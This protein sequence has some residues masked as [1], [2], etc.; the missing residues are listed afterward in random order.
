M[1]RAS[2]RCWR[3]G[4][5][6]AA[7]VLRRWDDLASVSHAIGNAR[8]PGTPVEGVIEPAKPL[9]LAEVWGPRKPGKAPQ[10]SSA[11][12]KE[13]LAPREAPNPTKQQ[14]TKAPPPYKE[15][16]APPTGPPPAA[17]AATEP[18]STGSSAD[19][20]KGATSKTGQPKT[21]PKKPPPEAPPGGWPKE[22]KDES[23]TGVQAQ[24]NSQLPARSPAEG[25]RPPKEEAKVSG[26]IT[27]AEQ[28]ELASRATAQLLAAS[29]FALTHS[30][31][32]AVA[33]HKSR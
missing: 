20:A 31:E 17:V 30:Q 9:P 11:A 23:A 1:R 4:T 27:T 22:V 6:L 19:V 5:C 33:A 12:A 26:E 8:R 14:R 28:E 29:G 15:V 3:H 24:P 2:S 21:V 10:T 13:V 16:Q 7:I 18:G 32:V 25:A